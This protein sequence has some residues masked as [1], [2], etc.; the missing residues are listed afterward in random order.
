MESLERNF[1]RLKIVIVDPTYNGNL[2]QVARAMSNFGLRRLAL[3]GGKADPSSEESRWF[4][5]E[6][7][8]D[9][10]QHAEHHATLDEAVAGCKM[11]IGTSRRLGRK[12]GT[13]LLAEEAFGELRPW[14]SPGETA[15]VFGREAHG[16]STPEIDRCQRTIWIPSDPAHPSLNLAHAVAVVCYALAKTARETLDAPP[17]REELELA[18]REQ[19][20]AMIQ[21]ARRVWIRIGYLKHQNPDAVLRSWRKL[22][23]RTGLTDHDV[24][25]VRG[26]LHQ[27]EW[28]AKVAGIPLEGPDGADPELFDKHGRYSQ[29]PESGE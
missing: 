14:S 27:T 26:L 10:L 1:R 2:G 19:V 20:E 25:I 8:A 21:Q 4:A 5:R 16:L 18:E 24:R 12:R 22:F 23:A 29:A 9:V 7:A 17:P 3:V 15:L 11:V 6:E 28:V 13:G